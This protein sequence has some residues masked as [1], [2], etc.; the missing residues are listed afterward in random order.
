MFIRHIFIFRGIH[1][2]HY[3]IHITV[4]ISSS[5]T[6]ASPS[7]ANHTL[8]NPIATPHPNIITA[9]QIISAADSE[10]ATAPMALE[11]VGRVGCAVLELLP[12]PPEGGVEEGDAVSGLP[13]LLPP[14]ES[15][16]LGVLVSGLAVAEP[17]TDCD[18][19]S[20]GEVMYVES[21]DDGRSDVGAGSDVESISDIVAGSEVDSGYE[22]GPSSDVVPGSEVGSG[23]GVGVGVDSGV[24]VG[25]VASPVVQEP[26]VPPTPLG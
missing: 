6:Q 1:S 3:I 25:V 19:V 8:S 12:E 14:S 20:A 9:A 15:C 17:G 24:G 21:P 13:L 4:S 7:L 2:Y 26:G 23:V 10:G 16:G 5:L 11:A 22:V 18:G